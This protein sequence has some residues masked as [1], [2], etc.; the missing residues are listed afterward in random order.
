MVGHVG[1]HEHRLPAVGLDLLGHRV[2]RGDVGEHHGSAL[3]G[4]PAGAGGPDAA[5]GPGDH[6]GT[7][8]HPPGH[9]TGHAPGYALGHPRLTHDGPRSG[10]NH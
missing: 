1:A 3:G 7:P 4:Q 6:G 10:S 8:G 5:G 9:L 2:R